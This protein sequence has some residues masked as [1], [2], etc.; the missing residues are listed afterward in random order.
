ML[1]SELIRPRLKVRDGQVWPQA[2]PA[3]YHNL[4]TAQQLSAIFQAHSG[5]SRN[6]LNEALRAY[7]GDRLD[8]PVIRGLASVLENRC[9][10]G[11]EPPISPVELRT[12]LFQRG[13][14]TSKQDLFSPLDRTQLIA[15]AAAHFEITPQQVE[16]ALFADLAEEQI[17][18]DP[19]EPIPPQDLIARYN[20]E[21][22]RGLLYWAREV[23]ITISDTYKDIFKYIKLFK[24]M[25][26]IQPLSDQQGYH[27]T[28]HG[29]IS[30]FVQSTIRYGLQFAKFM[31]ALLLGQEW[32]MEADVQPPSVRSTEPLRYTLDDQTPLKS[33]FKASGLFDSALEA[34]FAAEF[35]AKYGGAKRKWELVREDELILVGDT[36]MIPDFSLTHR[37]DGR[38][39]LIELIGFWHPNYLERK[40]EKVR[41]AQRTD[42]IL[43][44]YEKVNVAEAA[45]TE[46]SAGEV[47][48]FS[49]KPVL[50]DVLAVAERSAI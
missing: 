36:V 6:T 44:V 3:D 24:L 29:P 21:V 31:P 12:H 18:L 8:Y 15:E 43:I 46:A 16:T 37:K 4:G 11:N 1:K 34:D 35:E 20:L 33:H 2:L 41:Q 49:R 22:A 28:L 25:Y 17:L 32:R 26:T 47:L 23:R 9:T 14:V 48:T 7:E 19:G 38:R 42:L 10:F 30:P 39:A 40:L 50:K 45:L 13:P 5:Q 27:I